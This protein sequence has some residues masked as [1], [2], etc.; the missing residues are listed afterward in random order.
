MHMLFAK[1]L[2]ML[3]RIPLPGHHPP[4]LI[5]PQLMHPL[6]VHPMRPQRRVPRQGPRGQDAVPGGVLHVDVQVGAAHAHHHV[7]VDGQDVGDGLLDCEGV[8]L[9]AAPPS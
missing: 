6:P 7:Q 4:L 2:I 1:T 8:L 3:R 9:L 5:P